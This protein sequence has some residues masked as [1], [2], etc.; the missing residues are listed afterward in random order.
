[1]RI[2][3]VLV[4]KEFDG[5]AHDI[6]NVIDG[7]AQ[8]TYSSR[9]LEQILQEQPDLHTVPYKTYEEMYAQYLNQLVTPPAE[10]SEQEYD[11]CTGAVPMVY[12]STNDVSLCYSPELK[13]GSLS[14]WYAHYCGQHYTFVEHIGAD[15]EKLAAS[16]RAAW[17]RTVFHNIANAHEENQCSK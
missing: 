11:G 7:A 4:K 15:P 13:E 12:K 16:V 8:A 10:I 2:D 14:H 3:Y 5:R 17:K 6:V 1:M 9:P